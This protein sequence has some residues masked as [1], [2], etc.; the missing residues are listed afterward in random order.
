MCV[1]VINTVHLLDKKLS[2]KHKSVIHFEGSSKIRMLWLI[3]FLNYF[4]HLAMSAI[5]DRA[6]KTV[7]E[8]ER[9]Y[10]IS[11]NKNQPLLS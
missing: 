9:N 6:G 11:D 10:Q 2:I 1:C 5:T 3:H 4:S 8:G 7:R